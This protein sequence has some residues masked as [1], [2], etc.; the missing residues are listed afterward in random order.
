LIKQEST[1]ELPRLTIGHILKQVHNQHEYFILKEEQ[2]KHVQNN[3]QLNSQVILPFTTAGT[4][5]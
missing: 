5:H 2:Q 4:S 1:S 3:Q